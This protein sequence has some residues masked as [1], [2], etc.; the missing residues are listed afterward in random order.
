MNP[1]V[2]MRHLR[3]S[4]NQPPRSPNP[5]WLSG[6]WPVLPFAAACYL[7][8]W[9]YLDPWAR[10]CASAPVFFLGG[11]VL[12]Q[13]SNRPGG[14]LQYASALLAQLDYHAWLGALA[15]TILVGL[16]SL[17]TAALLRRIGAKL[18]LAWAVPGFLLLVLY[19]QYAPPVIELA[20]GALLALGL[21]LGWLAWPAR[22]RLARRAVFPILAMILFYV[23]G[24]FP[25]LLFIGVGGLHELTCRRDLRSALV[26][27]FWLLPWLLGV[28]VWGGADPRMLVRQWGRGPALA[29]G[30]LYAFFPV[31]MGLDAFL[32]RRSST[33]TDPK[34][35]FVGKHPTASGKRSSPPARNWFPAFQIGLAAVAVTVFGLTFDADRRTLVRI[36][37]E[38]E[39]E[40][41]RGV[42]AA[43]A[44]LRTCPAPARLQINRALFHTGRLTSDLFTFPQQ[45]GEDMLASLSNDLEVY[46][47][48]SDT[49]LE[50]GQIN[51][52]EHYAH[53]ALELRGERPEMLWRLARINLLKERPAAARVFLNV[54]GKVPFHRARAER[55]LR[56]LERDPTL[57]GE[58]EIARL[59]ARRVTSDLVVERR[60]STETL[61]RQSL[62]S[63]RGNRMAGEYLLAHLLLTR[64]ADQV[65][66]N[67][68]LLDDTNAIPRHLAEAILASTQGKSGKTAGLRGRQIDPE[69]ARRFERFLEELRRHGGQAA[70][71]VEPALAPSFG[72]TYWFYDMYG[73]SAARTARRRRRKSGRVAFHRVPLISGAIGAIPLLPPIQAESSPRIQ[74]G[75]GFFF[76]TKKSESV[77]NPWGNTHS[78]PLS[79]NIVNRYG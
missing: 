49:L 67:L 13:H 16:L 24:P 62:Q 22:L 55:W 43:A 34:A 8:V 70:A 58:Q 39:R 7:F 17:G 28:A 27:W 77:L 26:C 52:A 23:A 65:A 79:G 42:L 76:Y 44:R 10:Y 59:R 12:G 15:F 38:A 18:G 40:N 56:A 48:L 47:P 53:E 61:L 31:A 9:L 35:H 66:Q 73:R 75:L 78:L 74:S 1:P 29:A 68:S 63:N 50:L 45:N 54:L 19:G 21:L 36:Q 69:T 32:A 33:E 3:P 41:W 25:C 46:A 37:S 72:D 30:A 60:F 14:L 5:V 20:A 2:R 64:Q 11:D 6:L 4:Q 57:A 71:A 51:L